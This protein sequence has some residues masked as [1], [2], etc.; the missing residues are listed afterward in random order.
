M[1]TPEDTASNKRRKTQR[2]DEV[3]KVE[4]LGEN[5]RKR[6]QERKAPT[7]RLEIHSGMEES[8]TKVEG[9]RIALPE[10]W[11]TG[12]G[13]K[14]SMRFWRYHKKEKLTGYMAI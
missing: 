12:V 4:I 13:R 14:T 3:T 1:Q 5:T 2:D 9:S 11:E 7:M 6:P 8:S 10:N